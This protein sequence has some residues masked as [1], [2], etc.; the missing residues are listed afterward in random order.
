MARRRHRG[1]LRETLREGRAVELEDARAVPELA[2][3][4][5]ARSQ[6]RR[7]NI[8]TSIC[9]TNI[10]RIACLQG[11]RC[12]SSRRRAEQHRRRTNRQVRVPQRRRNHR[13][14][15][16]QRHP[17][18]DT[19]VIHRNSAKRALGGGRHPAQVRARRPQRPP[20]PRQQSRRQHPSESRPPHPP[21]PPR[22]REHT[23]AAY[24]R[25]ARQT[26]AGA[27]GQR[28]L[29]ARGQVRS[30][31]LAACTFRRLSPLLAT[32]T[33]TDTRRPHP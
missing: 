23:C 24:A 3:A 6:S 9:T 18:A 15:R 7:G 25:P 29:G 8:S 17:P 21:T 12:L 4:E 32:G 22:P 14:P 11:R 13:P 27:A 1:R 5:L 19:H 10:G 31:P 28:R 16:Q 33:G 30:A 26:A 2:T 20:R